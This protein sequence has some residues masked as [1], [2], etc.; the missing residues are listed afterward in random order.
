M[1]P[2]DLLKLLKVCMGLDLW[3]Q[4]GFSDSLES[5]FL[6]MEVDEFGTSF[7]RF[8]FNSLMHGKNEFDC[9][10]HFSFEKSTRNKKKKNNI[11]KYI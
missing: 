10:V 3:L 5:I 1:F 11:S 2:F 6:D 9:T 4:F 8:H 7:F